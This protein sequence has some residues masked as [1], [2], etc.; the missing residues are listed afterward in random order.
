MF[1]HIQESVNFQR[2]LNDLYQNLKFT[3]VEDLNNTINFL[4]ICV[5]R[6]ASGQLLTEI[7]R[8]LNSE[9]VYVLWTSFGAIKLNLRVLTGLV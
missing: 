4:D 8:K 1:K 3:K 7:Y 9:P 6:I 2:C 5:E